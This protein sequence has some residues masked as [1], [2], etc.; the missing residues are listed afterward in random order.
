VVQIVVFFGDTREDCGV[1]EDGRICL[2]LHGKR[3]DHGFGSSAFTFGPERIWAT[4]KRRWTQ[5]NCRWT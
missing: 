5:M 3:A 2:A 1:F 4:D